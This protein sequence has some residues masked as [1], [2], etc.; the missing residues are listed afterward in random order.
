MAILEGTN[1][2]I[3]DMQMSTNPFTAAEAAKMAEQALI[4]YTPESINKEFDQMVRNNAAVGQRVAAKYYLKS[5]VSTATLEVVKNVQ[6]SLGYRVV[7]ESDNP[8]SHL[9]KLFF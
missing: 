9:I 3:G 4:P 2:F 6:T 8:E 7:I 5:R 1:N